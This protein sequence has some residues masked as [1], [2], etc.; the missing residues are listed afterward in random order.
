MGRYVILLILPVI[1]GVLIAAEIL[2]NALRQH[3]ST[4]VARCS[5]RDVPT[6]PFPSLTLPLEGCRLSCPSTDRLLI[7]AGMPGV[8]RRRRSS[9][10]ASLMM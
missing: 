7:T 2:V 6:L 1:A 3:R 10:A 4:Y 5:K 9:S 8:V